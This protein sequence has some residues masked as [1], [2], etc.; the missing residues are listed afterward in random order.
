M[1][2]VLRADATDDDAR[3]VEHALRAAGSEPQRLA[4]ERRA[5]I[6]NGVSLEAVRA[7][8][9]VAEWFESPAAHPKASRPGARTVVSVLEQRFGDGGVQIIAGPCAVESPEQVEAVASA[10]AALGLRVLRGGAFKPRSSPYSFRGHGL[11]AMRWLRDAADRHGLAVVTEVMEPSAVEPAC[12]LADMLQ[13][14][15][16]NMQNFPLLAAAGRARKPVLLKRGMSATLEEWLLAAEYVLDGGN[17][18]VVLCERGVR[19]FDPAARNL[20][21]LAAVPLLRARTHLPVIVDPS[22]GVGVR[23]A[24]IPMAC[25]AVAAGADGVMIEVHPDPGSARSDGFQAL[26]I[27]MLGELVTKVRAVERAL[28]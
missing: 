5:Y 8:P 2:V 4:G 24:V 21:D 22:H 17:D 18:Q 19:S 14:G 25:A 26:T 16:R 11:D 13:I 9:A 12:E 28:R 7:L 23:D 6:A 10:C 20:L 15:S 3:A 27:P 1:I